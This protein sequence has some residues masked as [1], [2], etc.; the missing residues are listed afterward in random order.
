[1]IKGILGLLR[2]LEFDQGESV[3]WAATRHHR[4]VNGV[5]IGGVVMS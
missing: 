1:M 4:V 5:E 2:L 3:V